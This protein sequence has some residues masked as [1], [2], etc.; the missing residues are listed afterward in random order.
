MRIRQLGTRVAVAGL[1]T[2]LLAGQALATETRK[3]S[4]MEIAPGGSVTAM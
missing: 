2:I 3:E 4:R 1:A